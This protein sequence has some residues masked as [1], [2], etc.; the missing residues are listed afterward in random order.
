MRYAPTDWIDVV[1][2]RVEGAASSWV[3]AVLQ[4][5]SEGRRPVFHTWA[6]FRD[7]MV[8]RF[9]PVMEVEEAHKQRQGLRQTSRVAGY[10]QKFR[11]LQYRLLG[12]TDEEAFHAF[13]SG[14]QPHL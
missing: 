1:A 8:Q 9:E 6:Q 13:I 2:M 10:A 12:M 14:L 4:D 7:A 3:N 11:E 5:I